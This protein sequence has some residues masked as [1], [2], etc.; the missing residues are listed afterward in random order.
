M[1]LSINSYT[2]AMSVYKLYTTV[3]GRQ[4]HSDGMQFKHAGMLENF[5]CWRN[6]DTAENIENFETLHGDKL[7]TLDPGETLDQWRN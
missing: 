6:L 4:Y 1:Q 3:E 5:A 7:C 2:F